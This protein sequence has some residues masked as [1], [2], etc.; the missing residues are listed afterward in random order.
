MLYCIRNLPYVLSSRMA[1]VFDHMEI[2]IKLLF[3]RINND[4]C[5][6]SSHTV[7]VSCRPYG[8]RMRVGLGRI[9]T[10]IIFICLH[11]C[12]RSYRDRDNC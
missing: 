12:T 1:F 3:V 9:V 8:C 10:N 7:C 5:L 4:I 11:N 2:R 6:C